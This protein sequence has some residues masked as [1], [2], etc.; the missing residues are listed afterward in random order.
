MDLHYFAGS[1]ASKLDGALDVDR[2]VWK[3]DIEIWCWHVPESSYSRLT[4]PLAHLVRGRARSGGEMPPLPWPRA[5]RRQHLAHQLGVVQRMP[6]MAVEWATVCKRAGVVR[7][8]RVLKTVLK[9]IDPEI[10]EVIVHV[11]AEHVDLPDEIRSDLRPVFLDIGAQV[12]SVVAP[13]LG[14]NVVNHASPLIPQGA[15]V[16]VVADRPECG[17]PHVKLLARSAMRARRGFELAHLPECKF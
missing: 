2:I 12:V 7:R 1:E 9:R 5:D 4:G 14:D 6:H 11:G 3:V 8:L 10:E 15:G 13:I 16:P 17:V